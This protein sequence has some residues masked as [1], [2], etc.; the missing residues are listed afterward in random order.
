MYRKRPINN[1]R[2]RRITGSFGWID[3][4]FIN[5]G[6]IKKLGSWE[7]L[8]YLFLV[9]VADRYGLSFYGDKAISRLLKMDEASLSKVREGLISKSLID[10]KNGLY[11]VLELPVGASIR[12]KPA[13]ETLAV[14][15]ILNGILPL[16]KGELSK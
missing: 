12:Q 3:H 16:M 6:F 13:K 10:Y 5:T 11:Q 9:T 14:G 7:I 1:V 4:R 15:N 2:I 8:L